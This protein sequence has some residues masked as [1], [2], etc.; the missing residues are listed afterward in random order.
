[1]QEEFHL[2]GGQMIQFDQK[3]DMGQV[4][5]GLDDIDRAGGGCEDEMGVRAAAQER[6]A[7]LRQ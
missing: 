1:M 6:A 2:H 7:I 3:S 5:Y 4:V